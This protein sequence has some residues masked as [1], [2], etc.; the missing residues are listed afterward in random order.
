MTLP[1]APIVSTADA[2]LPLV[3]TLLQR[4]RSGRPT[5]GIWEAA[6]MQWWWRQE[7]LTDRAG[8]LFWLDD[9]GEP[10][11]AAI[12]S[13]F[14]D[15]IS[16]DVHVL[17]ADEEYE[18]GIWRAAISRAEALGG[19]DLEFF[20][21]ADYQVGIAELAAAG[22]QVTEPRGVVATWLAAG[23]RP[24]IPPLAAGYQLRSRAQTADRPHPMI[25]RNGARVA[26]RL[27][28]CSL[29]R[30]ELDLMVESAAGEVAGYGL[31]WADP[32]TKVGLVEPMRT[33]DAHQ[34]RGI[35][36]HLL[37]TGLELLAAQGCQRLKVSN[38]IDLYLRAR[39][40]ALP[41]GD[42]SGLHQG[43]RLP[44]PPG[45][46]RRGGQ[47]LT[48]NHYLGIARP[49]PENTFGRS[50]REQLPHLRGEVVKTIAEQVR[51]RE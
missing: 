9:L 47:R 13:Q 2:Y 38:D 8:Q 44:L 17:P 34:R 39:L 24:A 21:R 30:P 33:E 32:V 27:S 48:G 1:P 10:V 49:V 28:Q 23:Q 3:T 15:T 7:R 42:R 31:F 50:A 6:D 36:S 29:Y 51:C 11:A 16:C 41:G 5:G 25:G 20:A 14:G 12:R 4:L 22:Y 35:A 19:G 26:Q 40:P 18:R 43:L 37:A 45:G 46:D